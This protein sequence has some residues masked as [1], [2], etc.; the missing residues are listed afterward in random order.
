[1]STPLPPGLPVLPPN[2]RYAGRLSDHKSSEKISA[3]CCDPGHE[4]THLGD[5]FTDVMPEEDWHVALPIEAV[6]DPAPS[7]PRKARC[8]YCGEM[9]ADWVDPDWAKGRICLPCEEANEPPPSVRS[10]PSPVGT[11]AGTPRT[12]AMIINAIDPEWNAHF[13]AV[14]ADVAKQLEKELAESERLRKEVEQTA[15]AFEKLSRDQVAE[16]MR[17]KNAL[18]DSERQ[19][20]ELR[21][22]LKNL[23]TKNSEAFVAGRPMHAVD[24]NREIDKA[25]SPETKGGADE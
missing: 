12:D 15:E 13:P 8:G 3:Y 24:I 20:G 11:D 23:R 1:M 21:E 14:H 6:R 16:T 4:W 10:A 9:V 5:W 18:Q 2:T 17:V 22:F 19:A 25:L 7:E